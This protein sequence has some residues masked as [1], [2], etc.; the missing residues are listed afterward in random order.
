MAFIHP[1]ERI[2]VNT[3]QDEADV[4]YLIPIRTNPLLDLVLVLKKKK[5]PPSTWQHLIY[6][7]LLRTDYPYGRLPA[8]L[9][10]PA[11]PII[12]GLSVLY[13]A[14]RKMKNKRK[15]HRPPRPRNRWG[16]A[17]LRPGFC[18][19]L[20]QKNKATLQSRMID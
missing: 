11:K 19:P 9:R 3:K 13:Q 8:L 14:P 6:N 18:P 17:D 1:Q 4:K 2:T 16:S 7:G 5:P 15:K 20:K 10:S 12:S